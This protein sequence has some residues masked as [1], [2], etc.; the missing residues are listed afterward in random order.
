MSRCHKLTGI[1]ARALAVGED[2]AVPVVQL[3]NGNE[4]WQGPSTQCDSRAS[5]GRSLPQ[6]LRT[7]TPYA[8][9]FRE[10]PKNEALALWMRENWPR[11]SKVRAAASIDAGQ[12]RRDT[13]SSYCIIE[14]TSRKRVLGLCC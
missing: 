9:P 6:G 10:I 7:Y 11:H 13:R 4:S 12:G 5:E 14:I 8:Q 1:G 2:P 3:R